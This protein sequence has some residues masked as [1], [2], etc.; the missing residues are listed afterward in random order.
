[1]G[2][3]VRPREF[4]AD[5][6]SQTEQLANWISRVRSKK[7]LCRRNRRRNLRVEAV[8]TSV[9]CKAEH[10]L[11]N[12]QMT[13]IMKWQEMKQRL[14]ED[15]C[16]KDGDYKDGEFRNGFQDGGDYQDVSNKVNGYNALYTQ[17]QYNVWN[18]PLCPELSSLDS[19]MSQ[20]SEIKAP[21]Q[22]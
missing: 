22:R 16:Y 19:F 2:A 18:G 9:L 6:P 14:L 11:R 7:I 17:D 4:D 21:L 15:I 3:T 10:E 5:Q 12:K 13:R 20:L 1:M 8:L